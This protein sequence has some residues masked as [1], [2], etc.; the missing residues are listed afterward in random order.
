[1]KVAYKRVWDWTKKFTS[2]GLKGLRDRPERG[3]KPNL[4]E[5]RREAFREA[6]LQ[7]GANRKG[8]RIRGLDCQGVS[9]LNLIR[10]KPQK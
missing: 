6:V 10:R 7:L 5:N 2:E 9:F 1:M 4:P 8:E 3:S